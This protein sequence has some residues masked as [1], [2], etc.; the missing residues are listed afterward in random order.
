LPSLLRPADDAKQT[1]L[2]NLPPGMGPDSW[3]DP[4]APLTPAPAASA[5]GAA[6]APEGAPI[7]D[8]QERALALADAHR[9]LATAEDRDQI[10][11]ALVRAVLTQCPRVVL[12]SVRKAG[13]IALEIEGTI[14]SANGVTLALQGEL[15]KAVAGSRTIEA[16]RDLDLRIAVQLERADPC[17]FCPVRVQE[18][19]VLVIYADSEGADIDAAT[20]AS[21]SSLGETAAERLLDVLVRRRGSPGASTPS[22]PTP[23][24]PSSA[25]PSSPDASGAA[26]LS[27]TSLRTKVEIDDEAPAVDSAEPHG[28]SHAASG[29]DLDALISRV[30]RGESPVEDLVARGPDAVR[31]VMATFPGTITIE[32]RQRGSIPNPSAHGPLLKLCVEMGP[33]ISDELISYLGS[34]HELTRLYAAFC[35]QEIRDTKCISPL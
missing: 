25:A 31:R 18:R 29:E 5:G 19:T 28:D 11:G 4:T 16:A 17:V 6:T 23:S 13:L 22:A 32:P 26:A 10:T 20:R 27:D 30:V 3:P 15:G 7:T 24:T 1:L 35:F 33:V 8:P 12:F 34:T 21:I 14:S 2:G 9:Q